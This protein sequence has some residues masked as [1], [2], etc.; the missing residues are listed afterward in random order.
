MQRPEKRL[1]GYLSSLLED[2]ILVAKDPT[3]V[4]K[5]L[6][7]ITL[8][9]EE[10]G[11]I[12]DYESMYPFVKIESCLEALMESLFKV[13]PGLL[14]H[15]DDVLEMANLVCCE[16]FFGFEGHTYKQNR[17]VPMGSPMSGLLCKLVVKKI[18]EKVLHSF[19]NS[20]VYYKRY[21]DDILIIWRSNRGISTFQWR[22]VIGSD[23][24]ADSTFQ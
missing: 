20:I 23:G 16:S 4:V 9:D 15:R 19:R 24:S 18:E 12:L 8:M 10:V 11:A 1:H 13:N 5:E 3:V 22:A 21:V 14:H 2:S 17:G 7:D 6:Q